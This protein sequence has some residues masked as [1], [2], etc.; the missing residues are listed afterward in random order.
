M[1]QKSKTHQ[2]EDVETQGRGVGVEVVT[3]SELGV[4]GVVLSNISPNTF[5]VLYHAI[6]V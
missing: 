6:K 2:P 5:R 4:F 3:N 1:L